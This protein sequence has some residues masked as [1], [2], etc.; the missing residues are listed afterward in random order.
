MPVLVALA[1]GVLVVVVVVYPFTRAR[2]PARVPWAAGAVRDGRARS[3]EA[4]YEEI[5]TLELEHDLGVVDEGE[6]RSRSRALRMEAAISIRDEQRGGM[7]A[8]PEGRGQGSAGPGD[9][10]SGHA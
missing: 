4:V 6:Y 10:G 5:R 9:T 2:R 7:E 8:F 3:R 1:L